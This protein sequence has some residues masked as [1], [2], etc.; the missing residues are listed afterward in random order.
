M[1]F[2]AL[3][4]FT[5]IAKKFPLNEKILHFLCLGVATG[6]FYFIIDVNE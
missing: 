2:L 3:L 5:D 1:V 4:G 6:V